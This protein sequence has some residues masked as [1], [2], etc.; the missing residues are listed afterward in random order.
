MSPTIAT[1][2]Q[3]Y[4]H[5]SRVAWRKVA[6]EAV[7]LDVETAAYYSLDGA[8]LRLWELIGEGLALPAIL[9]ALVAE[10]DAPA[11]EIRGDCL[12]LIGVLKKEKIIEPA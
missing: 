1:H 12:E 4:K 9:D 5:S 2:P 3:T 10:F 8:G 6:D 11:D 7:I